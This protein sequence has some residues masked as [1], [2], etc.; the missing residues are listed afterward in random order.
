[1]KFSPT[2]IIGAY[3][4]DIEPIVDERG[5]FARNWCRREFEQ[6]GLNSNLAQCSV[7]FNKKSGTLRGMH[8]Q[9]TPHEETKLVRCSRGAI[10]DVIVDLRPKSASFRKWIALELTA[11][12]HRMLY[13]PAGVAHGFQ[14]LVDDTEVFYQISEFYHPE[15]TRG[16]RWNDPAFDIKWPSA[17][18]VISDKDRHYPDFIL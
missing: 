9:L 14:S 3:V 15:S 11:D 10:Y 17:E 4:I 5:F 8:Y 16:V 18:R 12:N 2:E 1:M 6:Q 7:S 13:V